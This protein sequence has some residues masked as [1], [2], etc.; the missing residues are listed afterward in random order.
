MKQGGVV[1]PGL[2]TESFTRA[3][4]RVFQQFYVEKRI[5]LLRKREEITK[6]LQRIENLIQK[7]NV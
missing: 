1:I 4:I 7:L 6:D 3:E 5:E 2:S